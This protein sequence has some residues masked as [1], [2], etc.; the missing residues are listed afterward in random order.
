M[1][2]SK[3][4]IQSYLNYIYSELNLKYDTLEATR[5]SSSFDCHNQEILEFTNAEASESKVLI[6]QITQ[7]SEESITKVSSLLLT[8]SSFVSFF[9]M[10]LTGVFARL[11]M[12]RNDNQK[13]RKSF[14]QVT[15]R[16]ILE[17]QNHKCAQCRKILIVV[18]FDHKNGNRAD[19]RESNCQALCPNCHAIKTRQSPLK[20]TIR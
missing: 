14:S 7:I 20:Y 8:S 10:I 4:Q 17:K 13:Q 5:N 9:V 18:D 2:G 1:E 12:G 19:S 6:E 3:N 15:R 16:R 11:I